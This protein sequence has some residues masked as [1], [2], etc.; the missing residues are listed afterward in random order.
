MK[1]KIEIEVQRTICDTYLVHRCNRIDKMNYRKTSH[2]W[3]KDVSKWAGVNITSTAWDSVCR[4][5]EIHSREIS[6]GVNCYALE[7]MK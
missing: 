7:A 3:A 5:Y 4:K 6:P 2:S 1:K